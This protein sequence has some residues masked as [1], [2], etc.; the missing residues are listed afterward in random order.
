[1]DFSF[2]QIVDIRVAFEIAHEDA[3]NA[4]T[5]LLI[6][7]NKHNVSLC[8]I[9][10]IHSM[11]SDAEEVAIAE[12][13]KAREV[14]IE[15]LRVYNASYLARISIKQLMIMTTIKY[16]KLY[17]M[18]LSIAEDLIKDASTV[19]LNIYKDRCRKDRN[20]K[21][22]FALA[23]VLHSI[24]DEESLTATM[25]VLQCHDMAREIGSFL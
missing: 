9:H 11:H 22:R 15:S 16:A 4:Y 24:K 23:A 21:R 6:T 12:E 7:F 2:D 1:M 10:S 25:K 3:D 18:Q 5:N 20:W 8:A 14:W 19:K 13:K 17:Q